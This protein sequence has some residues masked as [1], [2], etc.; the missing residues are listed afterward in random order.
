MK[1]LKFLGMVSALYVLSEPAFASTFSS[2]LPWEAPLQK[3]VDS[4]TGPVVRSAALLATT[5]TGVA[6]AFGGG[7]DMIQKGAK[8]GLG[9]SVAFNGASY[10]LPMFGFAQ[11]AILP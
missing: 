2:G 6:W 1:A 7:S 3:V 4:L 11:G 5:L 8:V 9:L 10:I